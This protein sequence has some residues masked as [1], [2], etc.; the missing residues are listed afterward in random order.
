[1][2]KPLRNTG[3]YLVNGQR[4]RFKANIVIKSGFKVPEALFETKP[5]SISVTFGPMALGISYVNLDKIQ[6]NQLEFKN[7]NWY[8]DFTEA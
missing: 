6:G 3:Y 2:L 8:G 1:M 4:A 5:T 7:G